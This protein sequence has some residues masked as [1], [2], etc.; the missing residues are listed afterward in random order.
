VR[1][2][3]VLLAL[4]AI[5]AVL[6]AAQA[7]PSTGTP[8]RHLVVIYQE[9]A[10]FDHYFGTY[11][12]A[13][14]PVGE[15]RFQPA[16]GTPAVDG[17]TPQLLQHNP[18]LLNPAR[19]DRADLF[20]CDNL[21]EYD[22]E[23]AA[24]NGGKMDRFVVTTGASDAACQ[25]S[26]VMDYY[27]GNTVTALWQYAQHFT[28]ADA[29]FGSTYG[30]SSVGALNLVAGQTHGATPAALPRFVANGTLIGDPDPAGDICSK[31]PQVSM[32]GRTVGDLLNAAGVTWGWFQGG[33]HDC[34]AQHANTAGATQ[35]DYVPHHDPF[36][37]YPSTA[38]P[39]HVA[40]SSAAAIG[41]SDAAHHQYDL[42]DFW[43]AAAA[44]RM[45]AVSFLK[46]PAYQNG[47]PGNSDP[48]DEQVFLVQT[49][50]RLMQLKDWSSMAIVV[51][52][53]DSDG[54]YDHVFPPNSGHSADVYDQLYGPG[55]CG[56]P[57]AGAYQDRCGLGPR[58]PLLAISPYVKPNTV[59]HATLE[60][61]SILRFI[62]D[63]WHLGRLGDQSFDARATSIATLFDFRAARAQPLQ[64]DAA[65]GEPVGGGP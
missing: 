12:H 20:P 44:G 15:P 21:H 27:D 22:A 54:W 65:T 57:A 60:Q 2:A 18:N 13:A 49:I 9:N 39:Q 51:A 48:L 63:N 11:P 40:P 3:F 8:I 23:Q 6:P 45:P 5:A 38:N 17:L 33:F 52:Y 29:F 32:S 7:E 28:L 55:N 14:N 19:L 42:S 30:P 31:Q 53:D 46:A 10:S 64:L 36:Q 41:T 26:Q 25:K 50:N 35:T 43:T 24:A 61:A 4:F 58:L 16:T 47:H 56:A 1:G 62:E 34:A 59:S 37:F